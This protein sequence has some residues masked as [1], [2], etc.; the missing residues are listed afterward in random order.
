VG[1][2]FERKGVRDLNAEGAAIEAEEALARG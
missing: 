2:K 1:Q